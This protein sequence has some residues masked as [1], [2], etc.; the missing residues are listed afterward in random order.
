MSEND[1]NTSPPSSDPPPSS[2]PPLQYGAATTGYAGAA[3]DKDS[4]TMGMLCHLLAIFTGFIGPLIIWLV[5]KDTSPFVD[6]QGKES[7][8]FQL[9]MLIAWVIAGVLSCFVIGIFMYPVIFVL[10]LVLCIMATMAANSG[11]AYRYPFA[12]R[13]IK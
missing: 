1:P 4:R 2:V 9:T 7:L 3:P 12:I 6:D 11:K 5:K 10:N 13:I 8:N